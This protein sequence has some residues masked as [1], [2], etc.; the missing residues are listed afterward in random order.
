MTEQETQTAE[1]E[2][3]REHTE[4]RNAVRVSIG[5]SVYSRGCDKHGKVFDV[6][7]CRTCFPL[8]ACHHQQFSIEWDDGEYTRRMNTLFV[9][10]NCIVEGGPLGDCFF[11]RND[12][13][14]QVV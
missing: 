5:Q 10:P 7:P 13:A 6:Q 12:G 11:V 1:A 3:E 9:S 4:L 8:G 2:A 14:L